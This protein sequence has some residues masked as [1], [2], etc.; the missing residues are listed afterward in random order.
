MIESGPHRFPCPRG[1]EIDITAMGIELGRDQ[2][3]NGR[4]TWDGFQGA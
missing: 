3:K 2:F 1:D 4:H